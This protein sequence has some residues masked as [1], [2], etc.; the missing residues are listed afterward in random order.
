MEARSLQETDAHIHLLLETYLSEVS[1]S[2]WLQT[3]GSVIEKVTMLKP[4]I[5]LEKYSLKGYRVHAHI[6]LGI[7]DILNRFL[8]T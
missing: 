1:D 2:R 7:L 5:S 8:S 4:K 6:Y 3:I